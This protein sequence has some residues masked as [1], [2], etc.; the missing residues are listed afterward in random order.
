MLNY[1][2]KNKTKLYVK[3]ILTEVSWSIHIEKGVIYTT[4]Q[5]LPECDMT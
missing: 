4:E 2:S 3:Q 1:Q 5:W